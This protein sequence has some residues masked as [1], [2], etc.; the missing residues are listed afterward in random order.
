[1]WNSRL[2][3]A[4]RRLRPE[5]SRKECLRHLAEIVGHEVGTSRELSWREANRVIRRLL[6]EVRVQGSRPSRAAAKTSRRGRST[7]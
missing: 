5:R 7:S 2:R 1:L 3:R 4:K 6:E